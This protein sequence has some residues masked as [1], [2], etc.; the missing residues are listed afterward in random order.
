MEQQP[1]KPWKRGWYAASVV[2][3]Y[4]LPN[5]GITFTTQ[6]RATDKPGIHQLQICLAVVDADQNPPV[7]YV[8]Y[9]VYYNAEAFFDDERLAELKAMAAQYKNGKWPDGQAQNE[10]I[11]AGEIGSLEKALNKDQDFQKSDGGGIDVSTITESACDVLLSIFRKDPASGY[12]KEV[13]K[14]LMDT[15][16]ATGEGWSKWF[17]GVTKFAPSETMAN[18][19]PKKAKS[20]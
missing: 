1:I 13:P 3:D 20:A 7:K 11:K 16:F 18:K 15:Y 4:T 17:Y 14:D 6:D 10:Y 5:N 12:T 19:V 9:S 2:P 8:N